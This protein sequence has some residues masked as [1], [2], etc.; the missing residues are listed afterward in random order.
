MSRHDPSEARKR[1]GTP[2]SSVV[3][4]PSGFTHV[5]DDTVRADST[6]TRDPL[7]RADTCADTSSPADNSSPASTAALLSGDAGAAVATTAPSENPTAAATANANPRSHHTNRDPSNHV[8]IKLEDST[9]RAA[10]TPAPIG[11][12]LPTQIDRAPLP[13]ARPDRSHTGQRPPPPPKHRKHQTIIRCD[14]EH[15]LLARHLS[16]LDGLHLSSGDL[17]HCGRYDAFAMS[18]GTSAWNSTLGVSMVSGGDLVIVE[19]CDSPCLQRG[20]RVPPQHRGV[21][22]SPQAHFRWCDSQPCPRS[23]RRVSHFWG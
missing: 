17:R 3:N 14:T 2:A 5:R 6:S 12:T 1:T 21:H 16:H 11:P 22:R 7:A 10:R 23:A 20:Q 18:P 8:T 19:A 13:A 9:P 15:T 4:D